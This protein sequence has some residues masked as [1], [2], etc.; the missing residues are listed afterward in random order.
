MKTT[1]TDAL[2]ISA[3]DMTKGK[4]AVNSSYF[5]DYYCPSHSASKWQ[6]E[7][8][9]SLLHF[10]N[11]HN[12]TT[13]TAAPTAAN[14]PGILRVRHCNEPATDTHRG[15]PYP[16]LSSENPKPHSS[17]QPSNYFRFSISPG[18]SLLTVFLGFSLSSGAGLRPFCSLIA[19]PVAWH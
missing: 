8:E 11:N 19:L 15:L 7:Q 4:Y 2:K 5:D 17:S 6:R 3:Q 13:E 16:L 12:T 10:N 18:L 14:Y 9:T 1:H